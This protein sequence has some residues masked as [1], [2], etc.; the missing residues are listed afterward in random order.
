[1]TD[2]HQLV[3]D[4]THLQEDVDYLTAL[5]EPDLSQAA[6]G[7]GIVPA[8]TARG[9]AN[10]WHALTSREAGHAWDTLTGWVDWLADRYALEDTLPG[11]WYRHGA[12]VDELDALRAAWTA[13]YLDPQARPND[14][15][16]WHELLD[17]WDRYG[18]AAGTHHDDEPG[19]VADP[20]THQSRADYL[21]ADV[22][23]R[24]RARRLQ[25]V[26]TEGLDGE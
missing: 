2:L 23:A 18:C 5:V 6:A 12:M 21:R 19:T 10:V 25:A 4:L 20:A 1:M 17:R 22:D 15:A 13:A 3:K 24:A 26:P 16:F 9:T 7:A 11:C 8:A 14:A